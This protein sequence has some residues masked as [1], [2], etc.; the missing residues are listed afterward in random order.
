M[1]ILCNILPKYRGLPTL[2]VGGVDPIIV[3]SSMSLRRV[4]RICLILCQQLLHLMNNPLDDF[5]MN[6]R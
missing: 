6:L 2:V 5:G 4:K 3:A 1:I